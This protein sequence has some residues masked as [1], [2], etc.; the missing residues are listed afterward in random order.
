[1]LCNGFIQR[2]KRFSISGS[3]VL[4]E[5]FDSS[6]LC[7]SCI[8]ASLPMPLRKSA[9]KTSVLKIDDEIGVGEGG[10]G[11]EGKENLLCLQRSGH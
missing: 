1:M 5:D 9:K 3:Q 6:A 4:G 11:G 10:K 8:I 7:T 2:R